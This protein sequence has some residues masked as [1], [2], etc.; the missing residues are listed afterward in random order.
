MLDEIYLSLAENKHSYLSFFYIY[1]IIFQP[2]LNYIKSDGTE[3]EIIL[4]NF[5]FDNLITKL[6]T[7]KRL[8]VKVLVKRGFLTKDYLFK[9]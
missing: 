2:H 7:S 8:L 1:S 3:S 5:Y 6:Y 4:T 9:K